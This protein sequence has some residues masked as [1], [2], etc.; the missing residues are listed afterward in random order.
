MARLAGYPPTI[1]FTLFLDWSDG[2]ADAQSEHR[3]P[4]LRIFAIPLFTQLDTVLLL[5]TAQRAS[6]ELLSSTMRSRLS[7]RGG[8][9][10]E[11]IWATTR[12]VCSCISRWRVADSGESMH[13][14]ES[15]SM[16][17]MTDMHACMWVFEAHTR[18][19]PSGSAHCPCCCPIHPPTTWQHTTPLIALARSVSIGMPAV[20]AL[21]SLRRK[22][23]IHLSVHLSG[24]HYLP[25]C[26]QVQTSPW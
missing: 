20:H 17:S 14:D 10:A 5:A 26:R 16:P 24:P 3:P 21:S 6:I 4:T 23:S 1:S 25:A 9:G 13:W 11:K 15:Q 7:A 19:S 8:R 18:G 2:R 22:G 12:Y